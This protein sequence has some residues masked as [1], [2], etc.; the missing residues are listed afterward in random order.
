MRRRVAVRLLQLLLQRRRQDRAHAE[1]PEQQRRRRRRAGDGK[2][3]TRWEH[4]LA[5]ALFFR[6][7]AGNIT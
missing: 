3:D 4:P 6:A 1:H 7:V 2:G 5:K